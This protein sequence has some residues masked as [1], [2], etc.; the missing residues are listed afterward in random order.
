MLRIF[1]ED[2]MYPFLFDGE[3]L[4]W[5]D[6][7]P[8]KF[9]KYPQYRLSIY[10]WD[11]RTEGSFLVELFSCIFDGRYTIPVPRFRHESFAYQQCVPINFAIPAMDPRR[12]LNDYQYYVRLEAYENA[13]GDPNEGWLEGGNIRNDFRTVESMLPIR[14]NQ[15]L[16]VE[17]LPEFDGT[18]VLVKPSLGRSVLDIKNYIISCWSNGRQD[19]M[20]SVEPMNVELSL[21]MAVTDDDD[22]YWYDSRAVE[23]YDDHGRLESTLWDN[24]M[25]LFKFDMT[26]WSFKRMIN[27]NSKLRIRSTLSAKITNENANPDSSGN[28]VS[29]I[30]HIDVVSSI[31]P[32]TWERYAEL[33]AATNGHKKIDATNMNITKPKICNR[34]VQNI[35]EM[36]SQTDSKANI[37]QPV[38]FRA[39][40]TGSIIIHPAVTEN[41]CINLDP[42]KSQVD[43]F[44]IKIGST[45]FPEL[46]R[47]ESGIIFKIVG[48]K[49]KSNTRS[50]LYYILN[51]DGELVTT[52]QF[53]TQS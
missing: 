34:I 22:L 51:Q 48:S 31:L 26:G 20:A 35:V 50:G 3:R 33:I 38:F 27:F 17:V 46:G 4:Y 5:P 47:V 1:D 11:R 10:R 49:L 40:E 29:N 13:E 28:I 52:G 30:V 43:N 6:Y 2:N 37:I 45:S 18:N 24:D 44:Y 12:S 21:E 25:Q 32:L 16:N 39:H 36:T 15:I 19:S 23:K 14:G 42:Y 8:N 53:Y 7:N 9:G 41:I